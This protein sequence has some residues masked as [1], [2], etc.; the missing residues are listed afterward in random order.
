MTSK[1]V[2]EVHLRLL[3]CVNDEKYSK[4][5]ICILSWAAALYE[6]SLWERQNGGTSSL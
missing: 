6:K 1:F 2:P 5:D 4:N 3:S